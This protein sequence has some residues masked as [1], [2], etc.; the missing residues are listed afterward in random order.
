MAAPSVLAAVTRAS[1]TYGCIWGSQT[2]SRDAAHSRWAGTPED[3][4]TVIRCT[5]FCIAWASVSVI[6]RRAGT[7]TG[8]WLTGRAGPRVQP[9]ALTGPLM[10][11]IGGWQF[12]HML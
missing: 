3:W 6:R 7:M 5:V 12:G 8:D 2:R 9:E 10:P 4:S 11:G 1:T